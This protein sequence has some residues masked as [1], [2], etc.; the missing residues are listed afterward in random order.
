M[1]IFVE[2]YLTYVITPILCLSAG[3]ILFRFIK[4]PQIADKVVALDLLIILGIAFIAVF[5][6]LSKDAVVL[7][8]AMIFAL[9]AFLSSVAFSY[10]LFKNKND[11]R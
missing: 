10:Y 2:N 6:I 11:D 8:V 9:I 7:D 4:G 3:F 5:S 1:S